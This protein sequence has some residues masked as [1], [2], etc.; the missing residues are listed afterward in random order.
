MSIHYSEFKNK[1]AIVTGG[2]SGLGESVVR[3]LATQG[4]RVVIADINESKANEL[5]GEINDANGEACAFGVDVTSAD[6]VKSMVDFAVEKYGELNFAVNNA[7]ITQVST[8]LADQEEETFDR[9]M[10]INVKGT[11][12]CMKYEIPE[13]I[14]S[15]G[16]IVN[17][18]SVAAVIG[19]SPGNACY[20]GSKHAVLGMT[21]SASL[22]YANQG[23]RI[24]AI[25][26]GAIDTPLVREFVGDNLELLDKISQAHPLGRMAEADE[27]AES[28]LFLLSSGSSFT[29]GSA[30]LVDGGYS[31]P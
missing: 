6:G 7:G 25:C 8:P 23:V 3:R 4:A 28:I 26:P 18:A 12:L 11:W 17:V 31:V 27:I 22:D 20:V 16:A 9:V 5:A 2:A 30:M 1:S 15:G 29:T 19:G 10:T 24:N 21:R 14:E 13:L